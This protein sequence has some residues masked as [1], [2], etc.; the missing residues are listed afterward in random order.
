M[1]KRVTIKGVA[2]RAGVAYQTVSKVI[3]GQARVLP[4]TEARIWE[5]ASALGYRANHSARSLRAQ[6]SQMIGYSWV[7]SQPGEAN[8]VLDLFLT[9][10]VAEA[11]SA[12]YHL[13]PFPFR[14]G[15]DLVAAYRELIEAG[16]VDG[17]V[18]SSMNYADP[19]VAF[20]QERQ[21]P[22]VAFGRTGERPSFPYVDVDGAGG[23]R[24]ATEHLIRLGHQRVAVLAWPAG[25]QV[26][27]DRLAGYLSAMQAAGRPVAENWVAR[28]EGSVDFGRAT[29]LRWLAAEAQARPTG[30]L[31]LN[32]T[33]AV[34][35]LQALHSLGLTP[36]RE[37]AV[38]G[39]DD[40]PLAQYMSPPLTTLRQPLREAG[41]LCVEILVGLL[42]DKPLAATQVL[43]PPSL[44]LRGTA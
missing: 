40:A 11:Q 38:I 20:L 44:I 13:L 3:N 15:E 7:P 28:G 9:S 19:R 5:A 29:T 37:V 2:A 36:G 14:E 34:G 23:L 24:A 35:A 6:R 32:D 16:R 42:E 1:K 4:E 17:F 22:F 26:G 31:A 10:M 21:V 8:P 41:R 27:D 39:F 43:L 18:L 12:G 30:I 25:S 33:A